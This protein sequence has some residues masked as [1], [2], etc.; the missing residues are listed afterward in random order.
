[1]SILKRSSKAST[2]SAVARQL[3]MDVSQSHT[4]TFSF[5]ISDV[6]EI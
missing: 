3:A 1:M 5:L 4:Q 6:S 2:L